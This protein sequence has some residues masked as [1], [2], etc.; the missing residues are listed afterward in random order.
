[1]SYYFETETGNLYQGIMQPGDRIATEE[2]VASHLAESS[3][4]ISILDIYRKL[5]VIDR[6]TIRALRKSEQ[7]I[8]NQ[9]EAEAEALREALRKL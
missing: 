3:R 8:L 1:M 9:L 7:A 5:D 6:K 4:S 2:E